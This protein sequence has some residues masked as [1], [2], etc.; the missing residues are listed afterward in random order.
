MAK[1]QCRRPLAPRLG[2]VCFWAFG[3]P[4]QTFLQ[5]RQP[6]VI[7]MDFL[8]NLQQIR[9]NLQKTILS[10]RK[11]YDIQRNAPTEPTRNTSSSPK[12]FFSQDL[13]R[14]KR[15]AAS[16][17]APGEV[18]KELFSE[19]FVLWVSG[20]FVSTQNHLFRFLQSLSVKWFFL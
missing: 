17:L 7:M 12:A 10:R 13:E 16:D 11:K 1:G 8:S 20:L 19:G 15:G 14:T 18:E 2:P 4:T 5:N 6:L 9:K 3:K